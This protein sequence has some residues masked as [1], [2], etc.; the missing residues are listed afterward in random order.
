[1]ILSANSEMTRGGRRAGRDG[2]ERRCIAT[3]ESGPTDRLIRFALSPDGEVVPDLAARL[4]GRGVWLTADRALAERAVK[5]RLFS[6][7]FRA[8]V[9]AADDLPDRL[10]ALL[11]ERLVALIGFA[12]KAGQAVTGAEKVRARILSGQAA[13]LL[14]ARDGAPG[15]RRKLAAL[16]RAAGGRSNGGRVELVELLD[17]AELGL[18]FGREFAIHAALDAGGFAARFLSEARRLSGFRDAA[19]ADAIADGDSGRGTAG[20]AP[21]AEDAGAGPEPEHTNDGEGQTGPARQDDL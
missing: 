16:A 13:V 2:P 9:K 3:G 20:C 19:P 8:Q 1:V 6:R 21:D 17:A 7:G 11:V 15:G 10:E 4:P 18:A 14:Q 5:K 12:R